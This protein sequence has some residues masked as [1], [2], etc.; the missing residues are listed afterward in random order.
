MKV[1]HRRG[2]SLVEA[3]VILAIVG[4]VA[5]VVASAIVNVREAAAR[6]QC[7]NN[8]H[9]LML[10]AHNFHDSYGHFPSNPDVFYDQAGDHSGRNG[11]L[12]DL[13]QPYL[14]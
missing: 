7:A 5:G 10:A 4:T 2:F 9:Q 11:T 6:I 1:P 12:Q 14:E 8:L 13:L 3:L